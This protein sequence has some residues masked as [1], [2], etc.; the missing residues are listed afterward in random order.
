[1]SRKGAALPLGRKGLRGSSVDQMKIIFAIFLCLQISLGAMTL[2]N[3]SRYGHLRLEMDRP[4]DTSTYLYVKFALKEFQ[5][6]GAKFVILELN[7]PGGEVFSAQKIAHLLHEC[8]AIHQIPVI[9]YINHWAL[10]AG[11]M[12]AYSCRYIAISPSSSMG[13]AEPVLMKSDG[14]ETAP[15]KMNSA[16]RAEFANIASLFGRNPLLAEAMVDKDLLLIRRNGEFLKLEGEHL[17]EPTDEIISQKGKLLTLPAKKIQEF[18]LASFEVPVS[19]KGLFAI[20]PFK[21]FVLSEIPFSNWRINFFTFLCHPA[22]VSL[23]SLAFMLGLYLE[24]SAPGHGIGFFIAAISGALL[25]LSH[26][27]DAA[28]QSL[29]M[30][31]FS[32][33]FL[34][35]AFELIFFATA[36]ILLILG[37]L[38][39]LGALFS[40]G[41]PN[42]GAPQ[43]SL[44]FEGWN[45][46]A[47]ALYE[48]IGW[49]CMTLCAAAFVI[50][51]LHKLRFPFFRK[52]ILPNSLTP[53]ENFLENPPI[54]TIAKT[55]SACRPF[56][57]IE[58]EGEIFEAY[59]GI[60]FIDKG[61]NVKII[62]I[63]SGR[64]FI[65]SLD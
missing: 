63:D 55:A 56:G 41:L 37:S 10:S 42:M 43:F 39:V 20:E 24:S 29:E 30:I 36:G 6:K 33:G 62:A 58:V 53:L 19:E 17:L 54:G 59:S 16:L 11:A 57:K 18:G 34:L 49:L 32:F 52:V 44:S 23:L 35:I 5:E 3:E 60:S 21:N 65:K 45:L 22:V 25:F 2:E 38:F 47:F 8:D 1:M 9:A 12:L 26:S 46:A 61:E 28:I 31:F 50:F 4:I 15:E 7:T 14:M 40:W 64:I 27:A 51:L 13:A 48:A